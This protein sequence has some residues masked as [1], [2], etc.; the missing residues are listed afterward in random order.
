MQYSVMVGDDTENKIDWVIVGAESGPH[1]RLCRPEW[2][3]SIVD[4][5]RAAD[6]PVF[7]KQVNPPRRININ[8]KVSKNMAEWP[9]SVRVR[10]I[11]ACGGAGF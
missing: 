2:I 4:Q 9:E 8:G 5:C 11:P 3:E 6:V 7:V 10:Q 1:A